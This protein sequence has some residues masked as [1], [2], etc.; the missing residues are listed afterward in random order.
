[1]RR[2]SCEMGQKE[3]FILCASAMWWDVQAPLSAPATF[4]H[5]PSAPCAIPQP[6]CKRHRRP[7]AQHSLCMRCLVRGLPPL[8]TASLGPRCAS[9]ACCQ[10][11]FVCCL[12][13]SLDEEVQVHR[14]LVH[15]F[16]HPLRCVS[17]RH[18]AGRVRQPPPRRRAR[19]GRALSHLALTP[20][21]LS[22]LSLS[23]HT[24]D[25]RWSICR[26]CIDL[27]CCLHG[28]SGPP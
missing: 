22:H 3:D 4:I 10:C 13:L 26:H 11:S 5:A 18:A 1:M 12:R 28:D 21:W 14:P 6:G 20:A 23:V 27:H 25:G 17:G 2:R 24:H 16:L 15:A 7:A 19:R 8:L 9:D